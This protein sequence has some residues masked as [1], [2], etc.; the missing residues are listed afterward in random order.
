[1]GWVRLSAAC[2]FIG[3]LQLRKVICLSS[4]T[5]EQGTSSYLAFTTGKGYSEEGGRNKGAGGG[6]K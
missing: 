3:T 4:S 6:Q 5:N 2:V 1:M